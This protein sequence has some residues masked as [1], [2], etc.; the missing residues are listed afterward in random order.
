MD[1]VQGNIG[2]LESLRTLGVNIA[3]DDFGT[4]FSSH[5]RLAQLPVQ[6]LKIDRLF[7]STM[8]EDPKAT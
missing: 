6:S 5:G 4:G 7:I 1:D 2:K 8:H 3:I